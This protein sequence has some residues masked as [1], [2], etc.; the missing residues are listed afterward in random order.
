[1]KKIRT[2]NGLERVNR[3]IYRRTRVVS[4]FPNEDACLRLVS[5]IL[6][7][8]HQDWATERKYLNLED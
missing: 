2:T 5:A 3:E 8:M 1:R 7:E 6:M 4:N